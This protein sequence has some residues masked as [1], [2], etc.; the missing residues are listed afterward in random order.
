VGNTAE[1]RKEYQDFL[2]PWKD[3]DAD[4]P[5]LIEAKQEYEKLK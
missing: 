2:V 5:L 1:A 4:L 3:G